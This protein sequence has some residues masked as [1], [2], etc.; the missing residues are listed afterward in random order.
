MTGKKLFLVN[1]LEGKNTH[2]TREVWCLVCKMV[3]CR[4]G[5]CERLDRLLSGGFRNVYPPCVFL[6]GPPQ[7][8]KKLIVNHC[9]AGA[10]PGS[11]TA[12]TSCHLAS[13]GLA[14]F[15]SDILAQLF[16]E[17]SSKGLATNSIFFCFLFVKNH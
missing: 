4:E 2:L 5:E 12:V 16:P 14:V 17:K 10:G 8:G 13:C 3:F 15:L 1:N 11:R 6:Q 7:S 9:L